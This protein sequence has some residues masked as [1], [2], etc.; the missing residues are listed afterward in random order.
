MSQNKDIK[1]HLLRVGVIDPI[2]ALKKYG[3]FRLAARIKDLRNS[4]LD[5]E[6]IPTTHQGKTFA[7]YKI[8]E[9]KV[10]PI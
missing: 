6:T 10:A 9:P 1:N 7:V 3:C 5:V 4:G 2:T 8:V